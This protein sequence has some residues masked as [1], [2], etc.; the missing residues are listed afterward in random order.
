MISNQTTQL[1][2]AYIIGTYP[3]LTMTF[4]DREITSL[5]NAGVALHIVSIRRPAGPL[6]VDQ[7]AI[8][9]GVRYLLPVAAGAFIA[10]H[11]RFALLR[12]LAYFG[13]LLFLLT[14]AHPTLKARIMTLLHFA[15]GVYAADILRDYGCDQIHAHFVD[16]SATL[17]LVAS[18][19]LRRPYSVTAHANDIYVEP[20]LLPEKLSEA[21][22]IV[23]CTRYNQAHLNRLG[24]GRFSDKLSCI[25]HGLE[26]H[27][28]QPEP[29]KPPGKPSILAVGQLKEKKGFA[30]LLQACREL[31]DRGYDL[32]CQIVGAGPLRAALAVDI[33]QLELEGMVQLCGALPHPAV[34]E[35]YKQSAI[36]VL[37]CVIGANGDR[38]GIPNVILEAMAMGLP[39]VSTR[40]SGIPE[41]IED[42]VNGILVPPADPAALADA[43]A[44]LLGDAR[45]RQQLGLAGRRTVI[46]HFDAE[47]NVK[48]LLDSFSA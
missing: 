17:A 3:S 29:C 14:R 16:R 31:K 30:Y 25:Y 40:H 2:L 6:S 18:R 8:G 44:W 21:R 45:Y 41:V 39:V 19:L 4:I 20:I 37:P 47:R 1:T 12:P 9:Q 33:R 36:F 26:L 13:T 27:E 43:L 11:L 10:G 38:D 24:A 5:R 15:E 7:Q 22:S 23:T 34:I 48:R 32:E 28:Y 46:E 35:K 42:G